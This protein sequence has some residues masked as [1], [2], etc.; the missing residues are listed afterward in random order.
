[1]SRFKRFCKYIQLFLGTGKF[2]YRCFVC[3]RELATLFNMDDFP[4]LHADESE[5]RPAIL[6]KTEAARVLAKTVTPDWVYDDMLVDGMLN[7]V[8]QND[9]GDERT[10]TIES[11]KTSKHG[12]RPVKNAETFDEGLG[13]FRNEWN[14]RIDTLFRNIN[15]SRLNAK[16]AIKGHILLPVLFGLVRR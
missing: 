13:G 14:Y 12:K 9:K 10:I 15:R 8:I 4:E 3:R 7:A 5:L 16:S 2:A 6:S 1:M 11:R